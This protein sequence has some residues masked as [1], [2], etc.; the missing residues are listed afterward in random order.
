MSS[1]T[2]GAVSVLSGVVA[3]AIFI[4]VVT[5]YGGVRQPPAGPTP[6]PTTGQTVDTE[7]YYPQNNAQPAPAKSAVPAGSQAGSDQTPAQSGSAPGGGT[8]AASGSSS[9]SAVTA[10][11]SA[12][13]NNP[14][15]T[16]IS[17]R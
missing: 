7:L 6:R 14:F 8:G 11:E 16:G 10:P 9:S 5:A 1:R 15:T 2:W 12:Q 4:A 13:Q 17:T 3:I